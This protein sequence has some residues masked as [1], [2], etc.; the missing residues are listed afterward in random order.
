MLSVRPE[1]PV[2]P[3][4]IA[5]IRAFDAAARALNLQYFLAGAMARDILLTHVNAIDAGQATVD[6]DFGV[7]VS[8]WDE[9]GQIKERL[10]ATGSFSAAN[11]IEHRVYYRPD[12]RANGYPVDIIP[13]R[14]VQT[15]QHTI[16]W[17]PESAIIMNVIAYEEVLANVV[18]VHIGN[19]L[20]VPIA[21]LPGLTLLKLFAWK[22]RH[23]ETPKDARDIAI[24]FR[25]YHEAGNK[26]RIFGEELPLLEAVNFDL[27]L[28][29]PRLLGK[30]VR[31]IASAATIRAVKT[32][33][34][35]VALI[36]RLLIHMAPVFNTADDNRAAARQMLEQFTHGFKQH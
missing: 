26:D 24:L 13:F 29:S 30:D 18:Q 27:E 22:D 28:A 19:A 36:D 3:L 33:L 6:V 1:R 9:F 35:D 15:Q 32:L 21:S 16:A 17:P 4:T 11:N 20:T 12:A 31:R 2:D 5:V 8:N 10:L 25:K 23:I 7:A 14:G 34:E